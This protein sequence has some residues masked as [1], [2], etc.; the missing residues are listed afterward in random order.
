MTN[1]KMAIKRIIIFVVLVLLGEI[2]IIISYVC[3]VKMKTENLLYIIVTLLSEYGMLG[4]AIA[5]ILT[6]VI[7][8]EGFHHMYLRV[9][10][11]GHG[12]YYLVAFLFPVLI[13]MVTGTIA[14]LIY[15]GFYSNEIFSEMSLTAYIAYIFF[16]IAMGATGLFFLALGE[17]LG[18]RG[19]LV[20]KLQEVM[21]MP[22]ALILGGI[23]WGV[24]HAP[25]IWLYGL[26]FGTEHPVLGVAAMCVSCIGMGNILTFITMKTDSIYP[27]A[28]GHGIVDIVAS[29]IPAL[30]ITTQTATE[31]AFEIG[32]IDTL[33]VF[34]LGMIPFI[35]LVRS[36]GKKDSSQEGTVE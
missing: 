10:W 25:S 36:A 16:G 11:K 33:V 6:R 15:G 29:L 13:N 4:P 7:T 32:L 35:L 24:W 28:I 12:K 2:P 31:H 26:D 19:Y 8:K 34:V 5:N 22:G 9:N 3:E 18:W 14:T 20:P 1:K 23:I 17:E 27:A 30:F 21:G